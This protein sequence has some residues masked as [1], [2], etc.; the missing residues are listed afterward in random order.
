MSNT[1]KPQNRQPIISRL[2]GD[3]LSANEKK[4]IV[5]KKKKTKR[6]SEFPNRHS[7]RYLMWRCAVTEF[8]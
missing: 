6:Q 4:R 7:R 1:P 8:A 2:S 5:A 3:A